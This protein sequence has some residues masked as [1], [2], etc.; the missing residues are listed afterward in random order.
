MKILLR[1]VGIV[2]ALFA[3]FNPLGLG[4]LLRASLFILGFDMM[5]IAAK[6]GIFALNFF[7]PV[8]GEAFGI[9]SWTLLLLFG[10]ELVILLTKVAQGYRL[11]IKPL[12]VFVATFLSL[13]LQPAIAIAGIDLLINMTD[14]IRLRKKKYK[15][16]KK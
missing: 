10:S 4:M 1:I 5:G 2:L 11:A 14:R 8:F 16:K 15:H 13:G 6:I 3:W 7:V 12:A 9:F